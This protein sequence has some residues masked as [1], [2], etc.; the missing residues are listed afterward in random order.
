MLSMHQAHELFHQSC[1]FFSERSWLDKQQ[2][3]TNII[4]CTFL[5][6]TYSWLARSIQ[7]YTSRTFVTMTGIKVGD[8]VLVKYICT[9]GKSLLNNSPSSLISSC[10]DII[11]TRNRIC[12]TKVSFRKMKKLPSAF[13][14]CRRQTGH[15]GMLQA[16]KAKKPAYLNTFRKLL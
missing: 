7:T 9:K 8:D 12:R 6:H 4:G 5:F 3:V 10:F 15:P 13:K 1:Y 11:S 2:W 14:L 16:P